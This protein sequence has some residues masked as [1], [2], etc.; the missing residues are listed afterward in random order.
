MRRA[1]LALTLITGVL[2]GMTGTTLAAG[3]VL[4]SA[5]F[6]DVPAG[7]PYDGA[8]GN[9]VSAKILEGFDDGTFRPDEYVTRGQLA[10]ALDRLLLSINKNVPQQALKETRQGARKRVQRKTSV[11]VA[12][13]ITATEPA[14]ENGRGAFRFAT[15]GF[16]IIEKARS[17]TVSVQ[18]V[19]GNT[20]TASLRYAVE[21]ETT[22]H[23]TDYVDTAGTLAFG[24]GETTKTITIPLKD[25]SASEGAERL[26][27]I[28]S[29]PTGA[30]LGSPSTMIVTILDDESANG[31]AV[32]SSSSS[33]ASSTSLPSGGTSISFDAQ[34]YAIGENSGTATITIIRNGG[35]GGQSTV[36]YETANGSAVAGSEYATTKGTLAFLAGETQKTF[37]IQ[38]TDNAAIEGMKTVNLSL[39]NPLG[40]GLG[41]TATA[42]L[43]IMD[44]EIEPY[45]IGSLKFQKKTERVS[46]TAGEA[47]LM[48]LRIGG[49][50]GIVTVDYATKSGLALSGSD[51][52]ETNGTLTF[53]EGEAGKSIRIPILRDANALEEDESF[54]VSISNATGGASIIDPN[55]ITVTITP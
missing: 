53:L 13:V 6:R 28:L 38:I 42:Q 16:S 37:A 21:D 45:G 48:V 18:R 29:N 30:S 9:M 31:N 32:Q 17:I 36:E 47:S 34:Q 54:S 8:V 35:T 7:S 15:A 12:S 33:A 41:A 50:K 24:N 43:A 14:V 49:S 52:A 55:V 2:L 39:K 26:R 10:L 40:A 27:I 22:T 19:N 51:Y 46:E 11:N 20:G 44:D 25:D 5:L 3:F 4:G 23:G 1:R